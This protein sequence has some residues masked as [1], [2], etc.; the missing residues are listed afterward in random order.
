MQVLGLVLFFSVVIR[1]NRVVELGSGGSGDPYLKLGVQL[2]TVYKSKMIVAPVIS[3]GVSPD[4]LSGL[5]PAR[6]G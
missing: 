2:E 6:R 1:R 4:F 3:E 5:A